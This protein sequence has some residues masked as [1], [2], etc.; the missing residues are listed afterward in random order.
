MALSIKNDEADALARE[1]VVRATRC[2]VDTFERGRLPSVCALTGKRSEGVYPARFESE[3]G[4]K[5]LL[6]FLGLVPFFIVWAITRKTALGRIPVTEDAFVT[7]EVQRRRRALA[8]WSMFLGGILS[9]VLG[10]FVGVGVE[11]LGVA[12]VV[13]G[14]GLIVAAFVVNS[15]TPTLKGFVE[16]SGRWVVITNAHPA[17]AEAVG[18]QV[19]LG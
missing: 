1:L 10:V 11:A 16:P 7:L 12:L 3:I 18:R 13:I 6:L 8:A 5:W 9:A 4:A 19:R 17:F 2:P 15:R 14:M